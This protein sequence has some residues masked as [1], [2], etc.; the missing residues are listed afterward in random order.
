LIRFREFSPQAACSRKG[1]RFRGLFACCVGFGR[2][3]CWLANQR[4]GKVE[5]LSL[6][7]C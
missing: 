2:G 3:R 6:L 7:R 4:T 5:S 1:P